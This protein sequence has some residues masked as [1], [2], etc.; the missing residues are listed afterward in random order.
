MVTGCR[1]LDPMLQNLKS[2]FHNFFSEA[3]SE[4]KGSDHFD[5][6]FFVQIEIGLEHTKIT[7]E[8]S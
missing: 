4:S 7:R 8:I 1:H 5:I 2:P 6:V 3:K